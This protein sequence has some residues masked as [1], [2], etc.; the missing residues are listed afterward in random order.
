MIKHIQRG[1]G[2]NHKRKWTTSHGYGYVDGS[3]CTG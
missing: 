2:G 3:N 1:V